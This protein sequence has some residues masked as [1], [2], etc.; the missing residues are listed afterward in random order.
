MSAQVPTGS[1]GATQQLKAVAPAW[2]T[3]VFIL[4]IVGLAVLQSLPQLSSRAATEQPSKVM[5]YIL[6]VAFELFLLGYVWLLGLRRRGVTIREIVGGRWAHFSDF[7]LDVGIA[8]LF[9]IVAALVAALVI[10]GASFALHFRG[11]DAAQQLRPETRTEYILWVPVAVI[12]GFCEEIVFRGYLQRQFLALT[13]SAA[14]AVAL[15][16]IVFGIGHL[17]QGWRG[18]IVI[19]VYGALFGILVV[20]RKSLR[21]GIMQHAG[22]DLASGLLGSFAERALKQLNQYQPTHILRF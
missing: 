5:T 10:A 4:F 8:L 21:P 20:L 12:A 15:Q 2:H 11:V 3:I 13:E 1:V 14:A 16:A 7:A 18:V 9:W 6:T 22:Q 17:Y 19:T